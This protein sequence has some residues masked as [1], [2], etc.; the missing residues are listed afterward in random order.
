MEYSTPINLPSCLE[1]FKGLDS[2]VVIAWMMVGNGFWWPLVIDLVEV[3][4][5]FVLS[6][7]SKIASEH[8]LH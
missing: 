2:A 6:S 5:S 8:C 7:L 4:M 3:G 1:L